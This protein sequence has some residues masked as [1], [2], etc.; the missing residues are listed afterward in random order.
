[1]TAFREPQLDAWYVQR[2]GRVLP[3]NDAARR[4]VGP[5]GVSLAAYRALVHQRYADKLPGSAYD[6][7]GE[8]GGYGSAASAGPSVLAA[9][10]TAGAAVG[11][12]ALA[13]A[14]LGARRR[15]TGR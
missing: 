7:A 10:W 13:G 9:A 12:S 2:V 14:V 15:A 6:R 1:G 8:G 4:S 3:L 5:D 11:V